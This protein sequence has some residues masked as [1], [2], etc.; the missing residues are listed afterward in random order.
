MARRA[1]IAVAVAMLVGCG[2]AGPPPGA[3]PGAPPAE[4]PP[5][6]TERL[7][8]MLP[9][10]AQIVVEVDLARLRANPVIGAVV[11]RAL[12]GGEP[13]E[14]GG[15]GGD[16]RSPAAAWLGAV[17]RGGAGP[18][19]PAAPAAEAV[20]EA[21]I[22]SPLAAADQLVLAAY[23]VGTAQ[24]AALTVVA[25]PGEL[26]GAAR[27]ADGVYALGPPEWVEQAEQRVALATTGEAAFAI[28]A[29]PELL[30]L[31]AHAVPAGAPG[32]S[33][34]VTARLSF[35]ARIALARLTGIDTAP[36][37]LSAWGDVVD[38]LAIVI[39]CDAVDPGAP[40]GGRR[41]DPT[42]RLAATLRAALAA[43]AEQPAIRALGLPASLAGAR[44]TAHGSWVRAVIAV[45]PDR[46]RR[47]V[48][49]A[50][51]LV[52]APLQT[53]PRGDPPS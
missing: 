39:D 17:L 16:A 8:A 1:E 13:G 23:G 2:G 43:V 40:S 10:G 47:I 3:A 36:A 51:E 25:A 24:A 11:T 34:R 42:A 33:L 14:R 29:A 31:R 9:Q 22:D 12:A 21:V 53:S 48:A 45:G 28:H 32:A 30:A 26:A 20:P 5:A 6:G 7:L 52:G 49:R 37:Q 50:A 38:D 18:G 19:D 41:A 44:L 35:D 27:L 46:L 15:P 4:P